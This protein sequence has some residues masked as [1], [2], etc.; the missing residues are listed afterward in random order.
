MTALAWPSFVSAP[1]SA[2][3]QLINTTL[4]TVSPLD[5]TTQTQ[6]LPGARWGVVVEYRLYRDD[7]IDTFMGWRMR[8][9]GRAGRALV[10]N[11]DRPRPRGTAAGTPLVNGA[12]QT[13]TS[14]VTD[15]WTAGAT[16]MAGDMI[17]IGGELKMVTASATAS[18]AGAMTIAFEPPLRAAPADNSAVVTSRPTCSM[19]LTED[20]ARWSGQAR[21]GG[22]YYDITLQLVESLAP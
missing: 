7:D 3:W 17:G 4:D 9:R 19:M 18:G 11:F 1:R 20:I 22:R 13:G 6:E 21:E 10:H 2:E 16:L 14:I 5:R 12:G 15:G 8:M